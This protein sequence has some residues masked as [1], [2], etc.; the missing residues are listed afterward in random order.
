M[1]SNL[2]ANK[3]VGPGGWDISNDIGQAH[4]EALDR[5]SAADAEFA[6]KLD[7]LCEVYISGLEFHIAKLHNQ[8]EEQG[9][10]DLEKESELS[11]GN[12]RRFK[13]IIL[14]REPNDVDPDVKKT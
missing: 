7:A 12:P 9:A 2:D 4:R 13:N 6:A 3:L 11:R 5:Q 14:G 10:K 1:P 8:G